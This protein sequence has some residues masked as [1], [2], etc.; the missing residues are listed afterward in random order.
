M[1]RLVD[2]YPYRKEQKRINLLILKRAAGVKYP[3][4]WRMIGG[5]AEEGETFYEAALRELKEET[6]LDPLLFW[7]I[8]SLNQFYD[9]QTNTI[10]QIPAFGAEIKTGSDIVLNHEHSEYKWISEDE[11]DD[12][13]LWPEQRRLMKLVVTIII[14]DNLLDEWIIKSQE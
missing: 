14:K 5:K 10:H 8:P 6:G 3:N 2:V 9:H 13:I 4:Q 12:Y 7:T 1:P 11:I